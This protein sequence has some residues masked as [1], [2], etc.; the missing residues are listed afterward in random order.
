MTEVV[1]HNDPGAREL[2][3]LAAESVNERVNG[4]AAQVRRTF[5]V[6]EEGRTSPAAVMLRGGRGG[7][8]RLKL[9]LS[10]LWFAASPPHDATYPARAWAS[11]LGLNDP[12][13]NGARRINEAFSWLSTHNFVS[14]QHRPGQ[15]SRV[16]LRNEA[17]TGAA[18]DVPG[19]VMRAIHE[20]HP[21]GRELRQA[22]RY[23]QVPATFWT[24][25]WI[26]ELSGAAVVMLLVVMAESRTGQEGRGVWF[27]QRV[28]AER[29]S[30]SAQTRS[31]GLS[32][33]TRFGVLTT[34][35]Q[36]LVS[37]DPFAPIKSRNVYTFHRDALAGEPSRSGSLSNPLL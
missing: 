15:P 4:R 13:G 26:T 30:L 23:I 17:G 14:L 21:M 3:R 5:V 29:Y 8:V 9:Y 32:E 6:A 2:A 11:L 18:Y 36:S 1:D 10:L 12:A 16:V 24:N 7:E 28:A 27:S 19:A 22:N 37:Q 35:K 25:G 31:K 34:R 33:L 20:D